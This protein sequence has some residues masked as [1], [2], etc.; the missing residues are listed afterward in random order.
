[1]LVDCTGLG[2]PG[3]AAGGLVDFTLARA[4]TSF[5]LAAVSVKKRELSLTLSIAGELWCCCEKI[6]P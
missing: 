3:I 1:M 2:A 6:R 5:L 4:S